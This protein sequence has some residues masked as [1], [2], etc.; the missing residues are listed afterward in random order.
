MGSSAGVSA[1][2]PVAQCHSCA[3]YTLH[4]KLDTEFDAGTTP[5]AKRKALLLR[6]LP[7]ST[8]HRVTSAYKTESHEQVRMATL[9]EPESC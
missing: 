5:A 8:T 1:R 7:D 9:R 4:T 6:G 3:H 2:S